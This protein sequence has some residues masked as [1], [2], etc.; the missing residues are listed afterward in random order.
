MIYF[1]FLGALIYIYSYICGNEE[2]KRCDDVSRMKK[3]EEGGN[4]T[5]RERRLR[6]YIDSFP[7]ILFI[8]SSD[9]FFP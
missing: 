7:D 6:E 8:F 4:N 3:E 9:P 1:A 2:E 5:Y